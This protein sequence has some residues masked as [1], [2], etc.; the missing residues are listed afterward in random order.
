MNTKLMLNDFLGIMLCV[1]PIRVCFLSI[2]ERASNNMLGAS[3]LSGNM[4]RIK[5]SE[6]KPKI[7]VC[8]EGSLGYKHLRTVSILSQVFLNQKPE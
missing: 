1:K 7:T 4:R 3:L 2:I 8:F 6:P 5:T